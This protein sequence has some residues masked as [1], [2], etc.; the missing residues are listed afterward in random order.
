MPLAKNVKYNPQADIVAGR[1]ASQIQE[2]KRRAVGGK[3]KRCIK[4]KSC[5]ATCIAASKV[6]MVDIPW[7]A[8]KGI[9]A[10]V[11]QIRDIQK[12]QDA[13]KVNKVKKNYV[14]PARLKIDSGD[15][16][17]IKNLKEQYNKMR[18]SVTL[19]IK[20]GNLNPEGIERLTDVLKAK[21]KA[22]L[23]EAKPLLQ[24]I[25]NERKAEGEAF[26]VVNDK[27]TAAERLL[28][29]NVILS[30]ILRKKLNKMPTSTPEER[31]LKKKAQDYLDG[32]IAK[33]KLFFQEMKDV[34]A[35][36]KTLR[37]KLKNKPES[38]SLTPLS[39]Q[40]Q[41]AIGDVKNILARVNMGYPISVSGDY[42]GS[43]INWGAI[44]QSG[45]RRVG[46]PG[47]YGAF[48]SVPTENLFK[49][50]LKGNYPQG[51]GIKGG[52]IG[53]EEAQALKKVGDADLGPRLI[54]AKMLRL[55]TGSNVH[56][57]GLIAMGKV[58]GKDLFSF[59]QPY[60]KVNGVEIATAF[61]K[62][63]KEIHKLGIAHNDMHPGN[64]LIDDSGKV[65]FVDFGLA[66]NNKKAA[67]AEAV[68]AVTKSDWQVTRWHELGTGYG[69][70]PQS[71]SY[72]RLVENWDRVK[73]IMTEDGISAS[74]ISRIADTGLRK[75]P[76][77]FDR[78]PWINPILTDRI[79]RY[80]DILYEGV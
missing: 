13:V 20:A 54:A 22:V 47:A 38:K 43:E 24:K 31:A 74:E 11:R 60:D 72:K 21:R 9:G 2:A 65:R 52:R 34:L 42:K 16:D 29:E 3:R 68:G 5:S 14:M 18:D 17:N 6:C 75:R 61:W 71:D 41:R 1:T 66:Q 56:E 62:A 26:K 19:Q 12:G 73:S 49:G 76:D 80:I 37:N 45:A 64:I 46:S 48:I 23:G 44:A 67:F 10:V 25:L 36:K 58:P 28:R 7:V 77:V 63:R 53:A 32:V 40:G 57:A 70:S 15:P 39:Y 30:D 79:D 78:G 69:G 59:S 55:E 51:V 8:S 27:L 50:D 33:N 4:G 35:E